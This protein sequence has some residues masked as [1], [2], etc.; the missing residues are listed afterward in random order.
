MAKSEG[1]AAKRPVPWWLSSD[2][3]ECGGCGQAY[4]REAERL[5][6]GCDEPLCPFCASF[7]AGR[8]F[9]TECAAAERS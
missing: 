6:A 7:I 4:A 9:C 1:T 3:E 2:D 8:A 5:C